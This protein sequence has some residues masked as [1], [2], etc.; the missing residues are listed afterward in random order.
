MFDSYNCRQ[1]ADVGAEVLATAAHY[2]LPSRTG[3]TDVR[4]SFCAHLT[5]SHP[6]DVKIRHHQQI[7]R[8]PDRFLSVKC[9]QMID[10][11]PFYSPP[12]PRRPVDGL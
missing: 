10:G 12:P 7:V 11:D 8:L 9:L 6:E 5:R 2:S 4:C 1:I 3:H